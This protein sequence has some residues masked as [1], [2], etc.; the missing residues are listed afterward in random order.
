M[1]NYVCPMCHLD[2]GDVPVYIDKLHLDDDPFFQPVYSE[3]MTSKSS[4]FSQKLPIVNS[5]ITE[6]PSS[7]DEY[8]ISTL[9]E[10]PKNTYKESPECN[11]YHANRSKN[12]FSQFEYKDPC[13]TE[14]PTMS[15]SVGEEDASL[16]AGAKKK[17]IRN[18]EKKHVLKPSDNIEPAKGKR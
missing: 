12:R 8:D 14:S 10:E 17:F 7:Y 2:I 18:V 11:K 13:N 15:K 6:N 4:K 1:E 9:F 16:S 5:K 3:K